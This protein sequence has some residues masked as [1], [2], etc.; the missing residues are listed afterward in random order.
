MTIQ[1]FSK[2]IHMD[3]SSIYRNLKGEWKD[4]PYKFIGHRRHFNKNEVYEYFKKKFN[5]ESL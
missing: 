2:W 1:E 3:K 4:L 5:K